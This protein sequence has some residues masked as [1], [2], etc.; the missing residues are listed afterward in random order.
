MRRPKLRD[1]VA[2]FL[3]IPVHV[4]SLI[5]PGN[6][7]RTRIDGNVLHARSERTELVLSPE[8]LGSA[9]LLPTAAMGRR[10]V[11]DSC[12]PVWL[13]N[14]PR[15]LDQVNEW[16]GWEVLRPDFA[17]RHP[18]QP[19]QGVGLA[20]SLGVDSFYSCFFADPAPDLLILAAGFD[21]PLAR[22]DIVIPM[23]NSLAAVAEATGKNW[24]MIETN[25][26]EHHLFRRL[27]WE[28][29][30][31]GAVAFLGH[32]L[33]GHIGT[34]LISSS[35]DQDHLG[36]WGS[37]P[38]VDPCWSSSR[39]TVKSI[40]NEVSR[41]EKLRRLV[42]HPVARSLIKEHLRVCWEYPSATGNCGYCHKCVLLRMTLRWHAPDL[43]LNTLPENIPLIDAIEALPPL[44]Q[45]L[46][47]NFRRELLGHL[48]PPVDS[49]L[50]KLIQRSEESL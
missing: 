26:R 23:C 14:A 49:A 33:Q 24:T 28:F 36:P 20:F 12:D 16:W 5:K 41:S 25:L 8:A 21:I 44:E 7:L 17:A 38:N 15:I 37:H 46:S 47:L 40:G 32:L 9:F 2:R 11:G 29:S 3:N 22:T 48:D 18:G 31:G 43:K 30:H 4:P 27:S 39:L 1:R 35:Y 10:L 45:N 42:N 6:H 13:E 34:L 50:R 19:K